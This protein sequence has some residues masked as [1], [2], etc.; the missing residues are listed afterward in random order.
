MDS[1]IVAGGVL[2]LLFIWETIL[3]QF[4]NLCWPRVRPP[5]ERWALSL[6]NM[7]TGAMK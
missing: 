2:F 3:N 6:G 1:G 7:R 5:Y 4:G